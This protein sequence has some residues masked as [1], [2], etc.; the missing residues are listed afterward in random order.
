MK[1]R[2]RH[3]SEALTG[4]F[5]HALGRPGF[6][7]DGNGL[8]P[9]VDSSGA[10]RW[11]LQTMVKGKRRDIWVCRSRSTCPT[12]VGRDVLEL[13]CPGHGRCSLGF[14]VRSDGE[15]HGLSREVRTVELYEI[16]LVSALPADS[17]THVQARS[18]RALEDSTP[19][20]GA[21]E[22]RLFREVTTH[23]PES[24]PTNRLSA[25]RVSDRQAAA[26][27]R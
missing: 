11:V 10:K 20:A 16:S 4:M 15:W 13:V 12:C 22:S 25:V 6:Y 9:R 26:R 5:I 19:R 27:S 21:P 2:G 24:T 1:R 18:R 23:A 3:P 17:G 14:R 7:A 8:Y